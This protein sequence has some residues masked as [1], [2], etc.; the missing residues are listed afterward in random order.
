[1][2]SNGNGWNYESIKRLAKEYSCKVKDLLAMSGNHDPFYVG[3]P[4]EVVDAEWFAREI[5]EKQFAGQSQI[6]LRRIHYRITESRE[7]LL[8]PSGKPYLNTEECWY[9]LETASKKARQLGLVDAEDFEDRKSVEAVSYKTGDYELGESPEPTLE[10]SEGMWSPPRLGDFPDLPSYSIEQYY[11]E[12]RYHLELWIEK[13][14]MN[15]VLEPLCRRY[16]MTLQ[17]GVGQFSITRAYQLARRIQRA[18][19]PAR[20]FYISDYD[21]AGSSMPVAVSR[22]LEFVNLTKGLDLDVKVFQIALTRDQCLEYDLP[23]RPLKD[24]PAN[25]SDRAKKIWNGVQRDWGARGHKGVAELDALE[26]LHPGS[27][28]EIVTKAVLHYYDDTLQERVGEARYELLMATMRRANEIADRH[29]EEL[30]ALR[31]EHDRIKATFEGV[32]ASH[33]EQL[34]EVWD[35]MQEEFESEMPDLD[36]YPVPEPREADELDD[37]LYDSAREYSRSDPTRPFRGGSLQPGLHCLSLV[38]SLVWRSENFWLRRGG[39]S[40]NRQGGRRNLWRRL[41]A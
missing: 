9:Y 17:V 2:S 14:T 13:S 32:I 16:G 38:T 1:M 5:W 6:H 36:G 3:T 10:V 21:P 7:P 29:E 34:T 33:N 39:R 23:V 26:G 15:D 40:R 31:A 24:L 18:G 4:T 22:K 35:E 25:R 20:I 30:E 37:A 8:T 19:K 12:Q 11:G 28:A 41:P 27:L